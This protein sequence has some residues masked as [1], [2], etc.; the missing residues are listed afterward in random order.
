VVRGSVKD[1]AGFVLPGAT[2]LIKG[3]KRHTLANADG[4]FELSDVPPHATLEISFLGFE[5]MEIA[6][7]GRSAVDVV[8]RETAKRLDEVVVIGNIERNRYSF[9]GS[10]ATVS[11]SS[12]KQI[13][14]QNLVESLKSLDPSFVVLE[15]IAAGANPNVLPTIEIRGQTS[16]I[17]IT[18]VDDMFRTDPNQPLF[19]LDGFETTLQ[20]IVDLDYNRV[21]SVSIL[22]DAASTAFYGSRAA[23]G[24]VVVETVKG[25]PGRYK[26]FYNGDYSVQVPDLTSYNMMNAEEKL[27]FERLSKRYVYN[28]GRTAITTEYQ[29]KIQAA[30][31][32]LYAQ[33][34]AEVRRGVNSYWLSEPLRTSLINRQSVRFSGG[35]NELVLD[36]GFSYRNAPGVMKGSKRDSWTGDL[37]INFNRGNFSFINQLG[38]SGYTAVE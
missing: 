16:V 9:T 8:L 33:R 30:L 13:G 19:I 4:K 25:E 15:N 3:T 21:A 28:A 34:L 32:M 5:N 2:I 20:K 17:N 22:K 12:L 37:D 14:S 11:G 7:N 35:N 23:N 10:M 6:L 31:D 18:D 36:A 1:E 24:I 26:F 38:L 29:A 27:E